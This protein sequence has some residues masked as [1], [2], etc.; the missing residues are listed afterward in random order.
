MTCNSGPGPHRDFP[1]KRRRDPRG[2]PVIAMHHRNDDQRTG[3][4]QQQA[5]PLDRIYL[6]ST[7]KNA[8]PARVE[9]VLDS[10]R[11]LPL[12]NL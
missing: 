10:G 6:R 1:N 12:R 3:G 11:D 5:H 8:L 4:L 2:D 9:R 7:D